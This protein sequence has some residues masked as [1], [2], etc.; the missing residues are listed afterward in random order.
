MDP[1]ARRRGFATAELIAAWPEL[2]GERYAGTTVPD[3]LKFPRQSGG[4]DEDWQPG[5][6]TIRCEGAVA[7]YLQHEIPQIIER[8]NGFFG[9]QVVGAV[10]IVQRPV[11]SATGRHG[12]TPRPLDAE[13]KQAI[14]RST[15]N[16]TDDGLRGALRKLGRGVYSQRR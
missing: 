12:Q 2:V 14:D 8:I 15:A 10:R 5:T 9:H 11:M 16:I 4:G 13:D 7:L 3:A 1:V 6:L